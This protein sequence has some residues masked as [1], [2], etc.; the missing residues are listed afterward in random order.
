MLRT[1]N[2][3]TKQPLMR[4]APNRLLECS[5]EM[6]RRQAACARQFWQTEIARQICTQHL[7][8][9][10]LLPGR[11]APPSVSRAERSGSVG[12]SQMRGNSPR[13][14]VGKKLIGLVG[15]CQGWKQRQREVL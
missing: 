7:L 1:L 9:P 6:P 2:A 14:V 12:L 8:C 13:N 4:S 3:L 10:P 11:Q 5:T 15:C